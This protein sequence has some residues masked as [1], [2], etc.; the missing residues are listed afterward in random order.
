VQGDP[1]PIHEDKWCHHGACA[2]WPRRPSIDA[3]KLQREND[4]LRTTIVCQLEYLLHERL[5]KIDELTAQVDQLRHR[6]KVNALFVICRQWSALARYLSASTMMAPSKVREAHIS[7]ANTKG[8][9]RCLDFN[10]TLVL[11]ARTES[12][13]AACAL[14]HNAA[15]TFVWIIDKLVKS[16]L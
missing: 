6:N 5:T 13:C 4:G 15:G 14:D 16:D 11:G 3:L 10:V 7:T 9:G 12:E 2:R 1:L 8:T